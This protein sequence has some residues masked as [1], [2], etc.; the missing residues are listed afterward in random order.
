MNDLVLSPAFHEAAKLRQSK[1][2]DYGSLYD[3]FPFGKYSYV[4]EIHKKAKRLV[5][6]T[7][8]IGQINHESIY[9]NLLDLI[10]HASYY[11]EELTDQKVEGQNAKDISG[12]QNYNTTEDAL[13][14]QF[15]ITGNESDPETGC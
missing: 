6:L 15:T 8:S 2:Q 11:F 13:S 5:N 4:H 10:N 7:Q 9:D 1:Q 12:P 14:E 3:Y